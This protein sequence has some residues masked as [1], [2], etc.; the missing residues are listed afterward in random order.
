MCINRIIQ[1]T[2]VLQASQFRDAVSMDETDKAA[3]GAIP[4]NTK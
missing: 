4:D 2:T 3:A 1:E